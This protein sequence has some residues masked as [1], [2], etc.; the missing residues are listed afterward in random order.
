VNTLSIPVEQND[1]LMPDGRPMW[2]WWNEIEMLRA[3]KKD[4]E[5]RSKLLNIGIKIQKHHDFKTGDL[6]IRFSQI[7]QIKNGSSDI[8]NII[9]NKITENATPKPNQQN[10]D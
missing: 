2:A 1:T 5:E 4:V 8:E 10:G 6:V 9:L 7:E 3:R